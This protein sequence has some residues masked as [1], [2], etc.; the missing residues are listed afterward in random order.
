M[1]GI[2]K[3]PIWHARVHSSRRRCRRHISFHLG[4]R[5]CNADVGSEYVKCT[6]KFLVT[7]SSKTSTK[8]EHVR[9]VAIKIVIEKYPVDDGYLHKHAHL[10]GSAVAIISIMNLPNKIAAFLPGNPSSWRR[11][12]NVSAGIPTSRKCAVHSRFCSSSIPEV[13]MQL[14]FKYIVIQV[15][16]PSRLCRATVV[17]TMSDS[18]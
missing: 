11:R 4:D 18:R 6:S 2:E 9:A 8:R 1:F 16:K 10:R 13:L 17:T 12:R 3:F 14:D 5:M 15:S 7:D